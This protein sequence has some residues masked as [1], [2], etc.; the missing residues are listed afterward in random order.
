MRQS[1]ILE[2]QLPGGE[3]HFDWMIDQPEI[4]NEHRLLCWRCGVRP[5]SPDSI[6]FIA[7]R[8]SNHRVEYLSYEGPISGDRGEVRRVASGEVVE[9]S[10]QKT[11]VVVEIRWNFGSVAY[12]GQPDSSMTDRWKFACRALGSRLDERTKI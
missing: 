11:G 7:Q 3:F 6:G 8:L 1:V 5:D 4:A 12:L 9:F 10:L 2:H